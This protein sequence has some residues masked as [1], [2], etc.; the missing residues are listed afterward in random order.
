MRAAFVVVAEEDAGAMTSGVVSFCANGP[1][2]VS[3]GTAASG[4]TRTL[5]V[6]VEQLSEAGVSVFLS[7]IKGDLSGLAKEGTSNAKLEERASAL[8]SKFTPKAFPVELYSLSGKKGA[9]MRATVLEFGPVL[10]SK[11]LD[12]NETQSGVLS[13]LF[14]YADDQGLPLVDLQDL[15]KVL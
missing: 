13:I 3:S 12:L 7:D 10:L 15:K 14:K 2:P 8:G 5:Q 4:K 11:I 6:I 1:R 9:Q